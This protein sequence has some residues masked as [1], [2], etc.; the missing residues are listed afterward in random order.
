VRRHGADACHGAV[1]VEMMCDV[2]FAWRAWCVWGLWGVCCVWSLS[3]WSCSKETF[4]G[5]GDDPMQT[6]SVS[7]WGASH[8]VKRSKPRSPP[9]T[10]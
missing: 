6:R 2:W 4:D 9:P 8:G 5:V 7:V 3:N 10:S 1:T